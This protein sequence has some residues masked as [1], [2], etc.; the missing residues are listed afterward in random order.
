MYRVKQACVQSR[1]FKGFSQPLEQFSKQNTMQ[2]HILVI[3]TYLFKSIRVFKGKI[4]FFPLKHV[5]GWVYFL[6]CLFLF[7]WFVYFFLV[8]LFFFWF[9]GLFMFLF[10]CKARHSTVKFEILNFIFFLSQVTL[11]HSN[12]SK[13]T[14]KKRKI[15]YVCKIDTL[16]Y[17]NNQV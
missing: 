9:V 6:V 7:F 13:V 3:F 10:L 1:S 17:D 11:S 14:E 12:T 8:C 5:H 15:M 4:I 16:F 2:V